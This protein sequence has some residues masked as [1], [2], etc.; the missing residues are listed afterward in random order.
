MD[1][2]V[3]IA[4][5]PD[6]PN[7]GV[8]FQAELDAELQAQIVAGLLAISATEEGVE[9]LDTAYQWQ[10][11]IKADDAYYDAFRQILQAAGVSAEDLLGD[12]WRLKTDLPRHVGVESYSIDGG[13]RLCLINYLAPETTAPAELKIRTGEASEV[14]VAWHSP[15][16]DRDLGDRGV[17]AV[18][19][20]D[21]LADSSAADVFAI[22]DR[23]GEAL[24]VRDLLRVD[25]QVDELL[26]Y[27][28]LLVSFEIEL[29]EAR[30]E[31]TGQFHCIQLCLSDGSRSAGCMQTRPWRL[32]D[33]IRFGV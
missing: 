22:E 26:E 13:W 29:D 17:P 1:M 6:I 5:E 32:G 24:F 16:G 28:G 2:T 27:L 10:E 20:R 12:A 31:Q 23:L 30:I 4:V 33:T 7:D 25:Q 3:V 15:E 18:R 14:N 21:A 9:A 19:Y 11:L 8:Q